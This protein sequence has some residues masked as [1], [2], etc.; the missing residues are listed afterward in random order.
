MRSDPESW[1]GIGVQASTI[2]TLSQVAAEAAR[3][4]ET[5]RVCGPGIVGHLLDTDDMG[6]EMELVWNVIVPAFK[7]APLPANAEATA[8]LRA[9]TRSLK[10]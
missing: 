4:M 8:Q 2:S 10:L 7:D 1:S 9:K 5:L 3:V 6:G